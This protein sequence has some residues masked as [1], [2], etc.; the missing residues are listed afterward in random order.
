MEGTRIMTE[1]SPRPRN[2][3]ADRAW[4]DLK[5]RTMTA[6]SRARVDARVRETLATLPLSEIRRA[7][8]LTQI[9]LAESLEIGQ[10]TVS[11]LERQ[12][13]MYISTLRRY[14]EALGGTLHLTAEFPDGR[15]IG[16]D[17]IAGE[18]G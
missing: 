18:G 11:K 8:G 7:I 17:R 1:R 3:P 16:I 12:S 6:E 2:S 15:R 9:D 13:D 10:G 4:Q 14:V 5:K